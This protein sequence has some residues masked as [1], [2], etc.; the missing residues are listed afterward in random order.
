[1]APAPHRPI[2]VYGASGFTGGLLARALAAREL[3]LVLAGRDRARL[4]AL[5][6]QV[7]AERGARPALRVAPLHDPRALAE[8][9]AGAAVV[10][11][12]AGPFDRL[13][14]PVV[15]AALAA[16]AHYVD[17]ANQQR[18]V[19][20]AYQ[21]HE[22]AARRAGLTVVSAL[23]VEGA[24]AD[25]LAARAADAAGADPEG[26]LDELWV[27]Y[28]VRGYRA[29][30]G[31]LA[32][33]LDRAGEPG[34]VWSLDR[35][36]EQPAA[37]DSRR[38]ACPP[39]GPDPGAD[40]IAVSFPGAEVITIPR[41]VDAA[42]VASYLA[43]AP[44]T[45]LAGLA[46]RAAGLVAPALPLLAHPLFAHARARIPA[47]PDGPTAE[48]RAD[49]RFAVVVTADRRATRVRITAVGR[50]PYGTT[51][52]I[53]AGAADLLRRGQ[54]AAAG[55]LAPAQAFPAG[56][57][58]DELCRRA[59]LEVTLAPAGRRPAEREREARG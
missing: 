26:P 12:C 8:A 51:A 37:A 5:A 9:F 45:P 25:W 3:P 56:P 43:V 24:L 59:G 33:L 35:W 21:R 52:E 30:R 7:A 58:L 11:N 41:H 18:F 46:A 2:V 20:D 13:G 53:L 55:V 27:V 50:D 44:A 19:L 36:E 57:A 28:A 48:Q 29:S 23:G 54:Q 15:A 39:L 32:S 49:A 4:A 6:D 10:A 17:P 34:R 40:R 22:S 42:R 14:E 47:G 38:V 16:G 31:S 1:M